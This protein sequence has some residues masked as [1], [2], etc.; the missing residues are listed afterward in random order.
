M[1]KTGLHIKAIL[2]M[3]MFFLSAELSVPDKADAYSVPDHI[4]V[5]LLYGSTAQES[6]TI[7]SDTGF[8]LGAVYD[9]G[10]EE[11]LPLPAYTSLIAS[12]E[13][14]HVTLHD[15]DGVLISADIGDSGCIM[16][17]DYNDNGLI[18]VGEKKYRGGIIF[19]AG[20]GG[21]L[22]VIN[23]LTMDEYLYGVLHREMSQSAPS[24]ALKAQAVAARSFAV[25]CI[26]RHQK[27]GFDVCTTSDCQT[28]GGYA[29]EYPSTCR[30]VDET[31]G[32][33]VWSKGEPV[34]IYYYK[35]SGGHTQG[36]EDVW[37]SIPQPHLKG[38]E[39]PF[40]PLYPWTATI[41]FDSLEQKLANAGYDPGTVKSVKIGGRN[42]AGAVSELIITGS[43]DTVRLEK[44]NI[45]SVLGTS[46]IRSTH[47]NIGDK[48]YG[49]MS[50]AL[51]T[52]EMKISNG[53]QIK[54]AAEN[55]YLLSASGN[56]KAKKSTDLYLY[57]NGKTV[58]VKTA[59]V[60][61]SAS[62]DSVAASDGKLT[63]SGVGFGHGVGMPQ[64]SAIEMARQ[65]YTFDEILNYY[66][67]DIEVR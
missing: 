41:Y 42:R 54:D 9:E 52:A 6:C 37:I 11:T 44:G 46:L 36:I 13:N 34:S 21:K 16:P 62:F 65:G 1:S 23:Y 56:A 45:R 35:N 5:G 59:A 38:V 12:V 61:A 25:D 32:L 60:E 27:D 67:A 24:E 49:G 10:F 22:T 47:F 57:S 29:D 17:T 18:T 19:E 30:A 15:I 48:Y 43:K 14:G 55:I 26:G 63:V 51:E 40:S 31:S 66:F 39:D 7:S 4:K 8:I 20:A 50:A 28:Y 53:S 3:L 33:L 2:L 64:D 58:K